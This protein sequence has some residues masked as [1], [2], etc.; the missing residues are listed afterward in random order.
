MGIFSKLKDYN[1]I[2]EAVLEKKHFSSL[3]KNLLLS[4]IYKIEI[5][6]SDYAKVKTSVRTKEE[7]LDELID[8]IKKYVEYVKI[9]EP[10]TEEAQVLKNNNVLALTNER[11]RSFLAYPTE[12][13]FLYAISDISPKYFYINKN[14]IFKNLLQ[15]ALVEGYCFNNLSILLDFN[16]W[17]WDHSAKIN[18]PFISNLI[19]QNIICLFGEKFLY[20]WRNSASIKI[21]YLDEFI[22]KIENL[23]RGNKYIFEVMKVLYK[24][25]SSKDIELLEPMLKEKRE[26]FSKIINREEYLIDVRNQKLKETRRVQKIDKILNNDNLLILEFEK[27]NKPLPNDKKIGNFKAFQNMLIRERNECVEKIRKLSDLQ[28]PILYLKRKDYLEEIT[29][30]YTNNE[31]LETTIVKTQ[32]N[33][34]K[35]ISKQIN[36]ISTIEEIKNMIFKIR[37]YKKINITKDIKIYDIKK[38]SNCIDSIMK[39]VIEKACELNC[40]K[41]ISNDSN[42]NFE[43]INNVLN[44]DI[45]DLEEIKL[46]VKIDKENFL[47]VQVYD[48]DVFEKN[49]EINLL[50]NDKH[51]LNIKQKKE[52]TLFV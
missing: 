30:I 2:L 9:V 3:S 4:M 10:E 50:N 25:A 7:F 1:E 29:E 28:N 23:D 31:R 20:D 12:G 22:Y 38:L 45:I 52:V 13:A 37:F 39:K 16:G 8:I 47:N 11:E 41:R 42:F 32:L 18:T 35:L 21:D 34:L 36:Q 48:K 15:N 33:F 27:F 46:S 24:T 26:E 51:L 19:Y 43:I 40:I 44:T 14:N 17:T 6:Y 49:F 5:A